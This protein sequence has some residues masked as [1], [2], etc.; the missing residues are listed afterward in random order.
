MPGQRFRTDY[1]LWAF[2]AACLFLGLGF[3]D[4]IA[5]AGKGDES[6]WAHVAIL[7]RRDSPGSKW[8]M[9]ATVAYRAVLQAVPSDLVG[10]VLQAFVV[11]ARSV[12]RGDPSGGGGTS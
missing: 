4:P 9:A 10:W 11:V 5:G 8:E 7:V 2:A 6:L 12:R 3:W 1:R